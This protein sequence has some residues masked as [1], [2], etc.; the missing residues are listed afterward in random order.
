MLCCEDLNSTEVMDFGS[1]SVIVCYPTWMGHPVA[2]NISIHAHA[3][4]EHGWDG[5]GLGSW[6][7]QLNPDRIEV[8]SQG[9]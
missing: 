8:A 3:R 7:Y 2:F 9:L 4:E 1:S 6:L 5:P